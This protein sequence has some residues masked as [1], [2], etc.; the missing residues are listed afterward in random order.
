MERNNIFK[1]VFG[2]SF[3]IDFVAVIILFLPASYFRLLNIWRVVNL[4]QIYLLLDGRLQI[5][6]NF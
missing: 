2:V 1:H 6:H 3:A 5:T 4:K